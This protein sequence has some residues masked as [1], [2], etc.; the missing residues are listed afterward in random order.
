MPHQGHRCR[1]R[2]P[3]RRGGTTPAGAARLRRRHTDLERGAAALEFALVVPVLLLL[4]FAT[5]QYGLYFWALQGG[6]DIAR[7][8]ARR[9][10][11]GTSP[12]CSDFEGGVAQ[13]VES[14]NGFG[15]SVTVRRTYL[16][17][18]PLGVNVGDTVEVEISFRSVDLHL[19]FVPFI[20]EGA[21]RTH[22]T[23]RVEHVPSAPEECL[24]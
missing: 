1:H 10:A 23:A 20:D 5:I 22:V 15:E 17:Q 12:T 8:A 16:D 14:L 21:V 9:S 18:A 4:V 6:S 13:A 3:A 19:P 2:P 11:V 7:D 24:P